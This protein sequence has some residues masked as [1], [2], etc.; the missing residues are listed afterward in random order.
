VVVPTLPPLQTNSVAAVRRHEL[1]LAFNCPAVAS[2][3]RTDC[4]S[5]TATCI[6]GWRPMSLTPA[7]YERF[8]PMRESEPSNESGAFPEFVVND[9]WLDRDVDFKHGDQVAPMH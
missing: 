6:V 4:C 9:R 2:N 1:T 7:I 5:A 3:A 8:D